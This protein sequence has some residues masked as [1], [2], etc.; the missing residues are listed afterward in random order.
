MFPRYHICK[1]ISRNSELIITKQNI[2]IN[3]KIFLKVRLYGYSDNPATY[4]K[5]FLILNFNI[6]YQYL[7]LK[8]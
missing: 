3:L 6:K 2:P 5:T 8:M 7:L 4:K 1:A